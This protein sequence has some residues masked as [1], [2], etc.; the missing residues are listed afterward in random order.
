MNLECPDDPAWLCIAGQYKYSSQV[1]FQCKDKYLTAEQEEGV[2]LV[3]F[4][5]PLI[6]MSVIGSIRSS[7]EK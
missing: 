7:G 6:L 1:L 3:L 2:T 5:V 4:I